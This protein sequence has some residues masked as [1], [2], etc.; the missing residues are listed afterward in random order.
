MLFKGLTLKFVL[1]VQVQI[2]GPNLKQLRVHEKKEGEGTN[3]NIGPYYSIVS[4]LGMGHSR[5]NL[6]VT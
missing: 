6:T 3:E 1:I 5:E 4:E 2:F